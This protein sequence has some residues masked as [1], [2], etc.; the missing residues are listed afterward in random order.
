MT[1]NALTIMRRLLLD[2]YDDIR[3]RLT[4]RLGSADHA[5]DA[6]QDTW[7]RL[8]H[9]ESV[10]PV[11]SPGNYLYRIALNVAE[12]HRRMERRQR[13]SPIEIESLLGLAD[14]APTPEQTVL[15][16]SDLKA[17]K[18]IVDELPERRREIF[19]AARIGNMSQHE[20]ADCLGVSRQL[21]TKE[22]GLA[23][24]HCLMRMK[25]LKG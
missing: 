7:L 10:G 20:I 9:T 2:R 12:D 19:M 6:M 23:L 14:D 25:E 13:I 15:A 22:I 1:E 17:F 11:K 16:R 24:R 4:K 8:A 5:S 3:A 21:V 18:A